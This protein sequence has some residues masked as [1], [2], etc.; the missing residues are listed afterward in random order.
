MSPVITFR[1]LEESDFPLMYRW[2]NEDH[3]KKFFGD[4]KLS[5]EG[6]AAKYL[7]RIESKVPT[8]PYIAMLDSKPFGYLQC[9]NLKDYPVF[10]GE[11]GE[12]SG[13]SV[14]LFIGET[15]CLCKGLSSRMLRQFVF[16]IASALYPDD[17]TC[18]ICH[19]RSNA[20]ALAMSKAAGFNEVRDVVEEGKPSIVLKCSLSQI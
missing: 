4:E 5:L 9:F 11:I 14:D 18:W 1:R 7:P 15:D 3:V 16:E 19:E 8:T 12:A 20:A 17:D 10:A 6:I 13:F 2:R